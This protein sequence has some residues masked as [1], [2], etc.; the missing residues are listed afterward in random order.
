MGKNYMP[1]K[2]FK[3]KKGDYYIALGECTHSETLEE[4]V[5]YKSVKTGELWVRPKEMFYDGR[6]KLIE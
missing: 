6:F 5:I 1:K 4:Y 3:H 2:Y